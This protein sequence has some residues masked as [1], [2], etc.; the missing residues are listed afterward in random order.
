MNRTWLL[1]LPLFTTGC[2]MGTLDVE[3]QVPAAAPGNQHLRVTTNSRLS[4]PVYHAAL[5]SSPRWD[6]FSIHLLPRQSG[7]QLDLLFD[8]CADHE[9]KHGPFGGATS[10]ET[11][12]LE[13]PF[14]DGETTCVRITLP[15][16]GSGLRST[17]GRCTTG[18]P[19]P[20]Q[21]R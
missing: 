14:V 21:G 1:A 2:Y 6:R 17:V 19:Q 13:K 15:P 3:V 7:L 18:E 11:V 12:H 5:G 8:T 4:E 9:C 20:G 16:I 10:S